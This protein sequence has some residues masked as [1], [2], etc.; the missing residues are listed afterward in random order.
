MTTFFAVVLALLAGVLAYV[1]RPLVRAAKAGVSRD[2]LNVA[3]YRDQLGELEADLRA[4]TLAP[5]QYEKSREEIERR[6]L[7]DVS[8]AGAATAAPAPR[9]ALAGAVALGVAI[10]VCAFLV[11]LAVGTPQA[12]VPAAALAGAGPETPVS[13]EQINAMVERLAARL[14]DNPDNASGWAMLGKS[15][16]VMGRYAEANEAF[17]EAIKRLPA[18]GADTAQLLADQ[19]DALAMAQ[20]QRLQGEPEKLIARA[21]KADPDNVKALALA[22]TIAFD[23]KDYARAE[24][25]WR[26]ILKGLPADSQLAQTVE[27]SIAEARMRA[28]GSAR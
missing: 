18:S 26:R 17:A 20:G 9:R 10:P 6:L 16:S 1:L 15:Y 27:D 4:G 23:S 8:A 19:A 12:V 3:V 28:R 21:L 11:Y 5:D 2:A 14:K 24:R 13:P 7:E 22:G 25:H